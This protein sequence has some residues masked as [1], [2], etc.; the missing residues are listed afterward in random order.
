MEAF[1][2]IYQ[3]TD[4]KDSK[5]NL[6]QAMKKIA[7]L[8]KSENQKREYH[9]IVLTHYVRIS[10][11]AILKKHNIDTLSNVKLEKNGTVILTSLQKS[12]GSFVKYIL[13]GCSS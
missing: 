12:G 13:K 2:T 4:P 1:H 11:P 10:T 7:N 3:F 5:E 9:W 6:K 8:I